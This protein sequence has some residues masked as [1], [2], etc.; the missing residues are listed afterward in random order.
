MNISTISNT[1]QLANFLR[2]DVGFLNSFLE[3]N[4]YILDYRQNVDL[5][6]LNLE[7]TTIIEKLYLKKKGNSSKTYREVYSVRTDTLKDILKII[8][9]FLKESQHPST[10]V[11]GY[12]QGLNIRTNAEMHLSKRYLLSVDIS[13]FFESITI[14]MV[15]KALLKVGFSIFSAGRLSKIVTINNFLPPGY[16][17]S[18]AISNLVLKNLDEELLQLCNKDCVYTRYAD[19]LYFSSNIDLPSLKDITEIVLNNGFSLNPKKTKYMPR[20]GKQYVTG[21][22][23]F[24]QTRPR[25]TKKIKR[26]IR[27]ELHY[28][29]LYGFRGHALRKLGYST[30]QYENE[31]NIKL[32]VD[33]EIKTIQNRITGWLRF[34]NS[35]E[36]PAAQKFFTQYNEVS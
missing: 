3:G 21:L 28:L 2:C 16:S 24:D 34:M 31:T 12:V 1:T 11:H 27:L 14:D 30:Q 35:V 29:K 20:G 22:T 17:T 9:S 5:P 25:I 26:N 36:R 4:Y 19:D 18:P 7:K 13:N 15:E 32:V 33:L 23:V 6:P 8:S 10:A